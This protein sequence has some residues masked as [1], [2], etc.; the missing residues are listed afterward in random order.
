MLCCWSKLDDG[1][2]LSSAATAPTCAIHY[3][4]NDIGLT[5]G[6]TPIDLA[7]AGP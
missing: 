7:L 5:C 2:T 4:F 1:E 3:T 6:V